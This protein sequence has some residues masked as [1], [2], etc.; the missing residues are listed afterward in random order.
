M[1]FRSNAFL[2][3]WAF[4]NNYLVDKKSDHP[5]NKLTNSIRERNNTFAACYT[6]GDSAIPLE[7]VIESIK[8]KL[9][10]LGVIS[11]KDGK[12]LFSREQKQQQCAIQ[13]NKCAC[14]NSDIDPD[15]TSSYEGDHIIEHSKGGKTELNNCEVLCL[16]C[17]QIK[18]KT[19]DVYKKMREAIQKVTDKLSV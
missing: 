5:E 18:S 2:N 16:S 15:N 6:S 19:P 13:N 14:C 17:H 9:H 8:D 7:F 3:D 11:V 1:L 12:R 10:N 4:E